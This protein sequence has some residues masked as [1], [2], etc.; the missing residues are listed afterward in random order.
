MTL[1]DVLAALLVVTI[2]GLAFVAIKAGLDLA[3]RRLYHGTPRYCRAC[4]E[5]V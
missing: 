5:A 4:R 1:R 2:L 3:E